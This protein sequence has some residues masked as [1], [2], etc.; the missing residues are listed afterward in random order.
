MADAGPNQVV[1]AGVDG[2]AL[3]RLDGSGSSDGDG[4]E[5]TFK[6]S[7]VVD[8]EEFVSYGGDG[9]VNLLDFAIW[10]KNAGKMP[11]VQGDAGGMPAVQGDAGGMPAVQMLVEL[12]A[13]SAVWLSDVRHPQTEFECGTQNTA[14]KMPAVLDVAGGGPYLEVELPVGVYEVTLVV[15]DGVEDSEGDVCLVTVLG[16]GDLDMDGEVDVEDLEILLLGRNEPADGPGDPRDL[17]GDGV[18]TVADARILVT[19]FTG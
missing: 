17:D 3:V 11:A 4:D 9:V 15:N 19:L 6:W 14:G 7:W 12:A 1:W 13:F 2:V 5:L 16:A 10:A 8:G 18:I